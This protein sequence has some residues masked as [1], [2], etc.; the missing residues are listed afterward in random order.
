[1]TTSDKD[2][3]RLLLARQDFSSNPG[4]QAIADDWNESNPVSEPVPVPAK[5]PSPTKGE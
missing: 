5:K 4:D 1:M 2:I 3:L